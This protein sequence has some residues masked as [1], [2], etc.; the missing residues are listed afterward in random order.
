MHVYGGTRGWREL[1]VLTALA[2]CGGGDPGDDSSSG[3][4]T[5]AASTGVV[6]PTTSGSPTTVDPTTGA[7]TTGEPTTTDPPDT[8]GDTTTATTDPSTGDTDAT[9][10][11]PP[12]DSVSVFLAQGHHGR[13][14]ISCDD[15]KTWV[16]NKSADDAIR[17]FENDI[18]CDHNEFAG[19]GIAWGD[20]QIVLTWGWG[21]PGTLVHSEDA[22]NFTVTLPDTPTFADVAYGNGRFVANNS[23]TKISDDGGKTWQ[24]GGP[25][26]IN[27]NTRAIEWV[28]QA[29]G[30][31]IV[32]G[33]SGEERAI[34]RS[35]DGV[36]WTAAS[37]RPPEC[38]SYVIGIGHGNDNT[39][40]VSGKG[41]VCRSTDAGDTWTLIP[42]S[43]RF[44]SAPVWTGS[45]FY[46][47][48]GNILHHS[49]T[50]ETW[51]NE[52]LM[53]DTTSIGAV[54]RSA[55]GT[56][57][58][59][60]DGWMT[61]YEKQRFFRSADGKTWEQ[62]P[63]GAFVGSHPINFIAHGTVPPGAGCPAN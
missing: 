13:T 51:D 17:C 54:T 20:K 46:V 60:N 50:G 43:D 40:V 15:G 23:M 1:I 5:A 61:W 30:M 2:G 9:T 47:Y 25:L 41:H 21:Q 38:G 14:T 32:T 56:F 52:V 16:Q 7:P 62:L 10:G 63:E 48:E 27:I 31:F 57:V 45:E 36:T 29:G 22:A 44:T 26:D 35:P 6:D 19:R 3:G 34:V 24:D 4:T 58:A 12:D 59:A 53:P 42:I 18:D 8:T 39:I 37:Q 55:A 49:A 11:P 28:P 33:E